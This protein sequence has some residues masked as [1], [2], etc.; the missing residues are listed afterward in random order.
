MEKIQL[1]FKLG[2]KFTLKYLKE[3][4]LLLLKPVLIGLV[5]IF[6]MFFITFDP[7]FAFLGI[8]ITLPCIF[9]SFW[10]CYWISYAI[11]P[12]AYYFIKKGADLS[13]KDCLELIKNDEKNFIKYISFCA[14]FSVFCY[15]PTI[16]FALNKMNNINSLIADPL[17][18]ITIMQPILA[19]MFINTLVVAP[20]LV[21]LNQVYYFKKEDENYFSLVKN[22]YKYLD[23]VGVVLVL[24]AIV[25]NM[26][27]PNKNII[28]YIILVILINLF[29]NSI[30][31]FWFFTKIKK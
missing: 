26:V 25:L 8:F 1:I 29:V 16:V 15:I 11:N 14:I 4:V 3:Y 2:Y 6:I 19:I 22:C 10:K 13:I 20:F 9:Y 18:V 12:C 28:L 17:S 5:G 31:T 23:F 21:F 27:L 24:T 7:I 30:N